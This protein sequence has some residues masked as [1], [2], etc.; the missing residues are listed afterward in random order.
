MRHGTTVDGV[1]KL[2]YNTKD[3]LT[4]ITQKAACM[5]CTPRCTHI[6]LGA[7]GLSSEVLEDLLL[8]PVL[9]ARQVGVHRLV[10]PAVRRWRGMLTQRFWRRK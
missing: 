6:E 8:D 3:T 5:P 1:I 10:E 2:C 4:D 7:L 9:A